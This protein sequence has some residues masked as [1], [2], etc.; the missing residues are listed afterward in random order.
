MYLFNV[1]LSIQLLNLSGIYLFLELKED[2]VAEARERVVWT[3]AG[4]WGRVNTLMMW[5]LIMGAMLLFSC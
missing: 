4:E 1:P 3:G 2:Q 5:I